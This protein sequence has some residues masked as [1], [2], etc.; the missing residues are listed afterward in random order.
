VAIKGLIFER[1]WQNFAESL[2]SGLCA[3]IPRVAFREARD[4]TL[5]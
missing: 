1:D 3:F 5:G 2:I 4:A